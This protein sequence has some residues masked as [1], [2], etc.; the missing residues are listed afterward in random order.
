MLAVPPLFSP[1]PPAIHPRHAEIDTQTAGWV[2][3]FE[4]GSAD[5]R[6]RLVRHQIGVFA[7]R[8]LPHGREEVVRIVA[9]FVMWLFGV[10]D[11]YCEEGVL[12][13][14]PGDLAG[15][16]HRLLRVAQN[17]EAPLL[18]DDPLAG[19]LRDLRARV[20]VYGTD[21]QAA[22]WV[23]CLREYA[24]SVVWEAS[25]RRAGTVPSLSDYTLMRLYDGATTVIFPLLQ[26]AHGYELPAD[27]A[28][29][30]SV[31]AAEEMAS[32]V[33]TWDNDLLSDHK[34][35]AG[36]GYYLNVLR[37]LES[38][39]HSQREAMALAIAQRDR[40]L[41]AFMHLT[42]HL[43]AVG[44]PQ[45]RQYTAGLRSFV[46]GSLDWGLQSVRYTTPDDPAELPTTV[47]GTA[48]DD[49]AEPLGIDVVAWW[50]NVVPPR[51]PSNPARPLGLTGTRG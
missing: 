32:F 37:V 45:M 11:G 36:E 7:A 19:G 31:R 44:S 20:D 42:D 3:A 51:R 40:V 35:R 6:Q 49:S 23:A 14:R 5:L 13:Q 16:L 15:T 2:E 18:L 8:I 25:H 26:M 1:I 33:I 39:G 28:D 30:K 48:T 12:G 46:R 22:R 41:T 50:W 9:D 4:I 24:L 10:D 17:P 21:T 29:D 27:E 34:E 43:R 47:A 38:D